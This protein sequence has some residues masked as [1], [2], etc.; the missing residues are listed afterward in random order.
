MRCSRFGSDTAL[1][2]SL[3]RFKECCFVI[4]VKNNIEILALGMGSCKHCLRAP[5]ANCGVK[6]VDISAV[7][8]RMLTSL[9]LHSQRE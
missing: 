4:G 2:Q 8:V 1:N 9:H 5:R 6:P 3:V 7:A